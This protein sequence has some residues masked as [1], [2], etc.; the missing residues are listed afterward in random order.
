[1]DDSESG[2]SATWWLVLV[3]CVAAWIDCGRLHAGQNSDSIL[4]VLVSLQH[5]TPFF[6]GEDRFGMLVP[7][8]ATPFRNPFVNLLAQGWMTTTAA[9]L[10]PFLAARYLRADGYWIAAGALANACLFLIATP[11]FQFD[12]LVTQ[13]YGVSMTLALAAL[14]LVDHPESRRTPAAI[15]LV[16][17]LLAHWVNLTVCVVLVPLILAR[18]RGAARPLSLTAAGV[19]GGALFKFLSTATRTTTNILP[20]A[21]WPHGWLALLRTTSA[22]MAHPAGVIVI[23]SLAVVAA[24]RLSRGTAADESIE[25]ALAALAE[26]CCYWFVIGT[27]QHVQLNDY[28][29]RYVFP[30]VLLI[31]VAAT[32][33]IATASGRPRLASA[34]ACA[35]F[36]GAAIFADGVPST[37]LLK[38][39]MDRT[40]GVLTPAVLAADAKVVMGD[41]WTVWPAV[42]H[43]NMALYERTGHA[44]IFGLA[45]RSDETD[46]EW[47][48]RARV[49][50]VVVVAPRFDDASGPLIDRIGIPLTF[51]EDRGPLRIYLAGAPRE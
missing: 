4:P 20:A 9:L 21:D 46:G 49:E 16:L 3:G 42:L 37:R 12:W 18:R 25:A 6:W 40:I 8:L 47:V 14:L 51:V 1:M 43:A 7:L 45:Y 34:I 33:L 27:F 2:R 23:A 32:L 29:A 31:A 44:G 39:E 36:V 28:F 11:P 19:A 26:A 48:Q 24:F 13:P 30:S 22:G 5:W 50:P 17:M 10:A 35:A 38:K 41:Y 15:A